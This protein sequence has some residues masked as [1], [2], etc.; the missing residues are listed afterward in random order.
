MQNAKTGLWDQ[1]AEIT[2][3]R[4]DQLSYKLISKGREF[5]RSRRMLRPTSPSDN[6]RH[7]QKPDV[8]HSPLPAPSIDHHISLCDISAPWPCKTFNN[9]VTPTSRFND[10]Q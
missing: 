2:K 10:Q 3:I 8:L 4:P 5:V 9:T 6:F 7:S 1:I